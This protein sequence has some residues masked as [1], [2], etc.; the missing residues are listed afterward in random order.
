MIVTTRRPT[1]VDDPLARARTLTTDEIRVAL[2][3]GRLADEVAARI[4]GP[5]RRVACG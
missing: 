3:P 5:W 1:A 2:S 4:A